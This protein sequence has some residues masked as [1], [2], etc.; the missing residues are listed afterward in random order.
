MRTGKAS[1]A[2]L[3]RCVYRP[4]AGALQ[5]GAA[6]KAAQDRKH[7]GCDDPV[8][9]EEDGP[10]RERITA[11]VCGTVGRT[12]D[13]SAQMYLAG[14]MN[15]LLAEG[16]DPE[17]LSVN[18]M[19]PRSALETQ[20]KEQMLQI[21]QFA[22]RRGLTVA[23]GHTQVCGGLSSLLL[24]FT[25]W[26]RAQSP[27]LRE[28]TV[29]AER[30][31]VMAG[32]AGRAGTAVLALCFQEELSERFPAALIRAAQELGR[33]LVQRQAVMEARRRGAEAIFDISMGGV[34]G[35]LWEMGSRYGL[36]MDLDLRKIPIRQETVELCEYFDLNPYQLYGQGALL[37]LTRSG[38]ELA[39]RLRKQ[40]IPAQ[41]IGSAGRGHARLIR[42]GEEVRCLEKPQ[43][44][45]LWKLQEERG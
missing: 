24:A 28:D 7:A 43:Q 10:P 11:S 2:V 36:A 13:P 4:L 22:A 23:C 16:A 25:M 45:M 32:T 3:D 40:G 15:H 33:G 17:G 8:S 29:P 26:G 20:L 9:Q 6:A 41:V 37:I 35:A 21:G 18:V 19:L 12:A 39:E 38:E 1:L 27:R 14:L 44:D 31:L 42:N 5:R 34:F 30:E